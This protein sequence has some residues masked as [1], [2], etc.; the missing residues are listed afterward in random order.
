MLIDSL[1]LLFLFAVLGVAADFAVRNIKYIASVLKIRLFAFGILL[2][3]ITT[4]PEL[5]VGINATLDGVASLSVGNLL[6]GVIV[7]LGLILGAGL[8]INR[9]IATDGK[10]K[11]LIPKVAVISPPPILLGLDGSYVLLDGL[12]MVSLYLGLIFYLY[13]ANHSF[14]ISHLEIIDKNKIVKAVLCQ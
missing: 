12:I 7:L 8:V 1:L 4:L 5:S 3:L 9:Q 14:G 11:K 13:R 2:G 6:G 10:L